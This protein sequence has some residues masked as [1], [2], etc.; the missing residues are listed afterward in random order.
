MSPVPPRMPSRRSRS[1]NIAR[2][3]LAVAATADG[4]QL[5]LLAEHNTGAVSVCRARSWPATAPRGAV[6]AA[7]GSAYHT[8]AA[9]APTA[10][11]LA[12][13]GRAGSL[14]ALV[15]RAVGP[16]ATITTHQATV[17][18]WRAVARLGLAGL[19]LDPAEDPEHVDVL[20]ERA[21]TRTAD[22]RI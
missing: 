8:A 9:Q 5:L 3:V 14:S 16:L 4:G 7:V 21:A 22:G 15:R 20:A 6:L 1:D 13:S 19:G 18:G 11:H 2:H 12:V 10:V 17:S